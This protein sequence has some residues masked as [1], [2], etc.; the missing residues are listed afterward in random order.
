MNQ[1]HPAAVA[2]TFYPA[3]Q[4]Q[5]RGMIS[6]FLQDAQVKN[7][8]PKAMIAPH[9]GYPY[10]GP[11]AASAYAHLANRKESIERV[12]LLGPAHRIH[13]V[14]FAASSAKAFATPLGSLLVDQQVLQRALDLPQVQIFD[15]AHVGE[16]SLEVHLPFLQMI[17]PNVSIVP[18]L[19]GEAQDRQAAE[20]LET[21]WSGPETIIVISSDLSHFHDY[22]AAK[23]LDAATAE[24]IEQLRPEA[25]G[26][27]SA[28]GR[29]PIRGLLSVAK[30]QGLKVTTADLRNSG[31]TAGTKDRVVGYGAFLFS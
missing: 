13:V 27:D 12:V 29:I 26:Q 10:S 21:V 15:Q 6:R 17:C 8:Q 18:L 2:G 4:D 25:I 9:A 24:A 19:A 16:H 30:R 22:T 23:T 7:I 1:I 31:D 3:D 14:G 28:C 20:L 11:V 5:L